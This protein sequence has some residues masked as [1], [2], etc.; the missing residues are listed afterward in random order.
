[1]V[2]ALGGAV[3]AS[4]ATSGAIQGLNV[5][6]GVLLARSLGPSGRGELAAVLLWPGLFVIIG[7]LGVDDAIVF[8]TARAKASVEAIVG[9]VAALWVVQSAAVIAFGAMIVPVVLG[10]YGHHVTNIALLY[11]GCSPFLLATAYATSLLQGMRRFGAFQLL[12]VG[13]IVL[14]A[15][16]FV[17]CATLSRL[18]VGTAVAVYFSASVIA[19]GAAFTMVVRVSARKPSFDGVLARALF[20]FALRSHTTNVSSVFNVRL[21]QLVISL[22]LAPIELGLYVTAVTLTS[23]TSLVGQSVSMIALPVIASE[24]DETARIVLVR[25]YV[26][27]TLLGATL[28]T[29]PMIAV[30]PTMIGVFFGHSFTPAA[31][32]T[33]VLLVAA[34][35]LTTTRVVQA[36][37]KAVGRP[38]EAGIS[39]FVALG[40]TVI[41]LAI[42]LPWLG[43][44][45]AGIASLLAYSVSAWW[46]ARRAASALGFTSVWLLAI[47]SIHRDAP[48]TPRE[49]AS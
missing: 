37:L 6:T 13:Q 27:L 7:S 10:H 49:A 28:L 16:G 3:T 2:G 47:T 25:H 17:V 42:L 32:V 48:D 5:I 30:T 20:G 12:R 9:T 23:L 26:R 46:T 45:G 19:A 31:T 29:V 24:Q 14:T 21:D 43:I 38:L 11:L 18:S 33:R 15:G 4:F 39:E 8:H 1:M 35:V 34:V 41:L 22:F 36:M 40:A 44:L